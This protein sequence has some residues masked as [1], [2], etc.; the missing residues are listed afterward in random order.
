MTLARTPLLLFLIALL[1]G[2]AAEP[3]RHS[4]GPQPRWPYADR[5]R[6]QHEP[7]DFWRTR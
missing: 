4:P 2:C 5:A 6:L 1:S 7:G 3:A